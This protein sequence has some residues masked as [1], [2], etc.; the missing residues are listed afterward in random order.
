[1]LFQ[2]T[3]I[4]NLLDIPKNAKNVQIFQTNTK[5]SKIYQ[6]NIKNRNDND[7]PTFSITFFINMSTSHPFSYHKN[8]IVFIILCGNR[9]ITFKTSDKS[10]ILASLREVVR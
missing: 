1:M 7:Y 5:A 9:N 4:E 10:F 8:E 2:N 6:K 3:N